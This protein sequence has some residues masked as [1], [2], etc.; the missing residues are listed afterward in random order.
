MTGNK[1]NDKAV[2][3]HDFT[4]GLKKITNGNTVGGIMCSELEHPV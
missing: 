1:D 4:A 3:G 2:E